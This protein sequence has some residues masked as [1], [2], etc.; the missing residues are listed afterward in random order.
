MTV[1]NL[2]IRAAFDDFLDGLTGLPERGWG[3]RGF[4]PPADGPSLRSN[5]LPAGKTY[6]ACGIDLREA[7]GLFVVEVWAPIG[8]EEEADQIASRLE[9][10]FLD[11]GEIG[12]IWIMGCTA[13]EGRAVDGLWR[14]QV[15]VAW[16]LYG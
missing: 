7:R 4:V 6:A 5:L 13:M 9:S 1:S 16:K 14:V 3:D 8:S 12:N 2:D 10:A 11:A 15:K